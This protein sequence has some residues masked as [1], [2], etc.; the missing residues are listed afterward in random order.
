MILG[1][2]ICMYILGVYTLVIAES[3][4]MKRFLCIILLPADCH[5][6]T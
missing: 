5:K 1:A 6:N 2:V 4:Y 3:V